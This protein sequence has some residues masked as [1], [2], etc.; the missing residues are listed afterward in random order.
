MF[1]GLKRLAGADFR[2][3]SGRNFDIRY[4]LDGSRECGL[5][6]DL[7]GDVDAIEFDAREL[8]KR[9]FYL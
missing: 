6:P 1:K 4:R 8:S 9:R 3:E 2:F 5:C 7:F